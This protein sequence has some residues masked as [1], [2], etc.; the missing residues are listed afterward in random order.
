MLSAYVQIAERNE[1]TRLG[2]PSGFTIQRCLMQRIT[3]ARVMYVAVC[4]VNRCFVKVTIDK[5]KG[6]AIN[7][8]P[9]SQTCTA[10]KCTKI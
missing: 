6:K 1:C 10:P 5:H 7:E 2:R 8:S 9:F 4:C 3:F